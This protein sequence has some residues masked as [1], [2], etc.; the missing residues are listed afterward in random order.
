M[1]MTY[2]NISPQID[3]SVFLAPSACVIGDVH[4]GAQS[5]LWFNVIVRGDVNTIRIGSRTNLQDGTIVHVTR[6]THPTVIGDDVTVGHKVMLHGC[7]IHNGSLIG[8]G[9]IV[10]DGAVIGASS[11]VAAGSLIAPGT[12]IPPQSLVMGSPGRVKRTLTDEECRN[13]Q[14]TAGNYIRYQ[15]HYRKNVQVIG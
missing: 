14:A 12:Q 4:I 7:T 1:I 10:L 11:L 5:S 9:A 6:H 3:D 2:K 13:M 15:E 8:I